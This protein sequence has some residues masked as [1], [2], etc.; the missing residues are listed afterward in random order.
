MKYDRRQY[1]QAETSR[2]VS[3]PAGSF[4]I[5]ISRSVGNNILPPEFVAE[6]I[7][8]C[9]VLAGAVALIYDRRKLDSASRVG[10]FGK[11]VVHCVGNF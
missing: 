5:G 3:A 2:S 4:A 7:R 8:R 11:V 1:R 9:T 6:E 10:N